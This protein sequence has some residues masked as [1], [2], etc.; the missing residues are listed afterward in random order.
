M[1][2]FTRMTTTAPS[3]TEGEPVAEQGQPASGRVC[4]ECSLCC[5]LM[6][7]PE[8]HKPE[9]HWCTHCKPGHGCSIYQ[10]R[11]GSCRDFGCKW[12]L[13]PKID[14]I[15]YPRRSKMVL[16]AVINEF[17]TPPVLMKVLIDR[18][19]PTAWRQEPY[20]SQIK[21]MA[22]FGL[23]NNA[24]HLRII[25]PGTEKEVLILPDRDI[26]NPGPGVVKRVGA[27]AWQFVPC[28]SDQEAAGLVKPVNAPR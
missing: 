11:P 27:T 8:L 17:G 1:E 6:S 10:Q 7:I 20:Y 19:Y 3:P 4:G 26:E 5:K 22:L 28:Q 12:L 24:F 18:A 21:Q 14:D 13:D 9:A 23:S 25:V 15:W 16:H 2:A